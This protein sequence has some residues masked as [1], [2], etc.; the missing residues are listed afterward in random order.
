MPVPPFSRRITAPTGAAAYQGDAALL[1]VMPTNMVGLTTEKVVGVFQGISLEDEPTEVTIDFFLNDPSTL[2]PVPEEVFDGSAWVSNSASVT[3]NKWFA[4]GLASATAARKILEAVHQFT[5]PTG[6]NLI[7]LSND[8][9]RLEDY[10]WV[11]IRVRYS[12]DPKADVY[13]QITPQTLPV[14]GGCP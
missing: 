12:T 11:A 3:T 4:Y 6:V 8:L 9:V 10:K 2:L 1:Y 7:G 13:V 14:R 5:I